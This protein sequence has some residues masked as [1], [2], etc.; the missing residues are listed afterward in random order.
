MFALALRRSLYYF[1]SFS[2]LKTFLSLIGQ[3]K[4][5]HLVISSICP[6][7]FSHLDT[8]MPIKEVFLMGCIQQ[9]I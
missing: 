8:R 3:I 7:K 4:D 9:E 5:K 6:S 1:L 2:S